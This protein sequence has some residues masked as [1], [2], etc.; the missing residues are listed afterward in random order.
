MNRKVV[1]PLLLLVSLVVTGSYGTTTSV[2]G[3]GKSASGGQPQVG[4]G[5]VSSPIRGQVLEAGLPVI[6]NWAVDDLTGVQSQDLILSTDGGASFNLKI[7][8]Y[9]PPVQHQLIWSA[10]AYNATGRGRLKVLLR[11]RGGGFAEVIS[12]DF[13]ILPIGNHF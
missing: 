11:L 10:A 1:L 5:R 6:L 13:S 3:R 9:L 4:R 12:E 2:A 8:A 7:A